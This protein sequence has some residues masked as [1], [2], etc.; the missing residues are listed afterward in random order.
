[1][2]NIFCDSTYTKTEAGEKAITDS[3]AAEELNVG[4][5]NER[6]REGYVL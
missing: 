2:A 4:T 5:N 1:M 3:E 6:Q